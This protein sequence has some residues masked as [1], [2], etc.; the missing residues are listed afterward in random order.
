MK[1]SRK[2]SSRPL[3]ANSS[4]CEL[5]AWMI[6]KGGENAAEATV[7]LRRNCRKHQ[8]VKN[9][10]L[11]SQSFLTFIFVSQAVLKLLCLELNL[12][13]QCVNQTLPLRPDCKMR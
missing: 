4:R 8:Q 12:I 3:E 5:L 10:Y 13:S 2:L 1:H 6:F 11:E 9:S 7:L